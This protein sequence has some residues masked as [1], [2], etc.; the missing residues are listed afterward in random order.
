MNEMHLRMA[1]TH[2]GGYAL[3]CLHCGDMYVPALPISID[4]MLAASES[5]ANSH[6]R[7]PKPAVLFEEDALLGRADIPHLRNRGGAKSSD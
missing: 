4:M 2:N 7:C 1:N 5:F 6:R 3:L